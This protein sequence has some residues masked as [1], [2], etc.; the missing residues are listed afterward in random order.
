MGRQGERDEVSDK[1]NKTLKGARNNRMKY[2]EK[3]IENYAKW[4]K[5]YAP[6]QIGRVMMFNKSINRMTAD[7]KCPKRNDSIYYFSCDFCP[8]RLANE[9]E[10]CLDV[11]C[12]KIK[13]EAVRQIIA[14]EARNDRD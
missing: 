9:S 4:L 11:D 6:G 3:A 8:L 14:M 1:E 10:E 12:E 5:K 2:F 13:P 7:G